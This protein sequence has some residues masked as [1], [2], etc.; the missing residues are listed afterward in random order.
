MKKKKFNELQFCLL[1][2]EG[3]EGGDHPIREVMNDVETRRPS[4]GCGAKQFG[5]ARRVGVRV[6][7]ES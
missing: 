2:E 5:G 7:V 1:N 6:V 4:E 3:T